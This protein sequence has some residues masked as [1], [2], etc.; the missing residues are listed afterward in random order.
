[1]KS[2]LKEIFFNSQAKFHKSMSNTNLSKVDVQET[3]DVIEQV[4]VV[5]ERDC[6]IVYVHGFQG[7]PAFLRN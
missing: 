1:M 4:G 6:T 2:L 7:I 3:L 5:Y